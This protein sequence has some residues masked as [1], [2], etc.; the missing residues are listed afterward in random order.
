MF[1]LPNEVVVIAG[2]LV[3]GLLMIMI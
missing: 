3:L 1:G 2:L